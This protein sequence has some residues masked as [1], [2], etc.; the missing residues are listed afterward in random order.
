MVQRER[1][2]ARIW[3]MIDM[4]G[5]GGSVELPAKAVDIFSGAEIDA[6]S[7]EIGPYEY[8]VVEF[9]AV[10]QRGSQAPVSASGV[11]T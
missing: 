1:P 2:G 8:R 4:N 3:I 6:G 11:M 5:A 7:M 9:A 10:E